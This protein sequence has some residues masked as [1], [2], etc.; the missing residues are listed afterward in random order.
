LASLLRAYGI[1]YVYI[2]PLERQAFALTPPALA[3]FEA[4]MDRVYATDQVT[5]Y[6]IRTGR[7]L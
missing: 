4:V 5:I 3:K 7:G 2:G 1:D 6:A